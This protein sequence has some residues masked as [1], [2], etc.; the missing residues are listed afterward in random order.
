MGKLTI[1]SI[2]SS[3]F[4]INTEELDIQNI[5]T[6]KIIIMSIQEELSSENM[7]LILLHKINEKG[8][9]VPVREILSDDD[10]IHP[11]FTDL[12]VLHPIHS[13]KSRYLAQNEIEYSI[14]ANEN[15]KKELEKQ[16]NAPQNDLRSL[17]QVLTQ[18]MRQQ[19]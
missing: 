16:L 5:S 3:S 8:E 6:L 1:H 10:L 19:Y 7:T 17:M 13:S 2:L 4:E 18:A 11:S 15:K 14:K 9:K 12:L